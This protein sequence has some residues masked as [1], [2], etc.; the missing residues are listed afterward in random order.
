MHSLSEL[1]E[2]C[3]PESCYDYDASAADAY[4]D[5]DADDSAWANARQDSSSDPW[6]TPAHLLQQQQQSQQAGQPS[7]QS[8]TIPTP[9]C[10]HAAPSSAEAYGWRDFA[11]RFAEAARQAGD[12]DA[13]VGALLFGA[14]ESLAT[15]AFAADDTAAAVQLAGVA[16]QAAAAGLTIQEL[17]Q[18][19]QQELLLQIDKAQQKGQISRSSQRTGRGSTTWQQVPAHLWA[20]TASN[21]SSSRGTSPAPSPALRVQ[22]PDV[23]DASAFPQLQASPNAGGWQQAGPCPHAVSKHWKGG[24]LAPKA[25]GVK[26]LNTP[27]S[28]SNSRPDQPGFRPSNLDLHWDLCMDGLAPLQRPGD[29]TSTSSFDASTPPGFGGVGSRSVQQAGVG[30]LHGDEAAMQRTRQLLAD[31]AAAA[32]AAGSGQRA[33]SGRDG[34]DQETVRVASAS[35]CTYS[36][37]SFEHKVP[38]NTNR[39]W[40]FMFL[41]PPVHARP[42]N[43]SSAVLKPVCMQQPHVAMP[44]AG[45]QKAGTQDMHKELVR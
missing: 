4:V 9:Q 41:A 36:S 23:D 43:Q 7:R 12:E 5:S 2:S 17:L 34:L 35:Y 33:D 21:S 14:S 44:C 8:P 22:L 10:G 29:C 32:A 38:I 19:Q 45:R 42:C 1:P 6:S 26:V 37:S 31:Q 28:S 39:G 40:H 15:A 24:R 13:A 11:L 20:D 27:S 3:W 30:R 25:K 16:E 18:A